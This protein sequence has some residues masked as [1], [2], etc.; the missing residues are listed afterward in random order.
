MPTSGRIAD[1]PKRYGHGGLCHCTKAN[2]SN[3]L[4]FK[5]AVT[6]L[7]L[8][9]AARA[10]SAWQCRPRP[11]RPTILTLRSAASSSRI[12]NI[13]GSWFAAQK[14]GRR[15]GQP[16]GVCCRWL[17][18]LIWSS[19][20]D[21]DQTRGRRVMAAPSGP[22]SLSITDTTAICLWR[23]QSHSSLGQAFIRP[24]V[25]RKTS[26]RRHWVVDK[27]ALADSV[28]VVIYWEKHFCRKAKV[29]IC[30]L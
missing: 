1:V 14:V 19:T 24:G 16:G 25:R 27:P 10:L 30:L 26:L 11:T 12:D 29:S 7:W 28:V 23:Y 9:R 2:D 15:S 22:A 5:W 6:A 17:L 21:A 3:C 20:A 18:V 4:L 8:C 13:N